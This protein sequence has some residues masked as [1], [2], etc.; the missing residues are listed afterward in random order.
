MEAVTFWQQF[1]TIEALPY[2]PKIASF[3]EF[4]TLEFAFL[5]K[6]ILLSELNA[7]SK[8]SIF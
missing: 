1:A 3:N 7:Y 6:Q 2:W 5:T 4:L 8:G